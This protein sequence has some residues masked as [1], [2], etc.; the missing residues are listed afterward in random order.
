MAV[1]QLVQ[2][3]QNCGVN[4]ERGSYEVALFSTCGGERAIQY[5]DGTTKLRDVLLVARLRLEGKGKFHPVLFL[6]EP[7][8][9]HT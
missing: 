7:R 3:V 4:T 8:H 5:K 1:I 9:P 6:L 2:R